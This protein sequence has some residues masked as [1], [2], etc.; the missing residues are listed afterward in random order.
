MFLEVLYCCFHSEEA[1][2]SSS[3]YQLA[4]GSPVSPARYSEAFSDLYIDAPATHFLF[5]LG[6]GAFLR[7][8]AFS[9]SC[10][11]RPGV[12]SPSFVS[13]GWCPGLLMFVSL[14]SIPQRWASFLH[15]LISCLQRLALA[16]HGWT[17]RMEGMCEA[18]GVLG[19]TV[20]QL[21]VHR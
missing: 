3:L 21:G 6:R 17:E 14:L 4:L 9:Q 13:L 10:K 12:E 5:P 16:G 20:G 1:V 8:Y 15:F 11:T 19:V 18:L 2:T 7:L